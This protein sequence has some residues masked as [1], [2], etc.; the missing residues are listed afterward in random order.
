MPRTAATIAVV[1]L[2]LWSRE[3]AR[4]LAVP[5]SRVAA[6]LV[7]AGACAVAMGALLAFAASSNLP[8]EL[9]VEL[10]SAILG[11]SFG[12]AA[13]TAGAIGVAL[14]AAAPPRTA[15][16]NLLA[17]LPVGPVA[18]RLGQLLPTLALGLGY[19]LALSSTAA[20]VV[21]RTAPHPGETALGLVAHVGLVVTALLVA[22]GIF[23]LTE[24]AA[25]RAA[26]MPHA[27]AT[28]LA[29]AVAL[30]ATFAA[31]LPDVLLPP[32]APG[33]D[34]GLSALLPHRAF[35]AAAAAPS[36]LAWLTP[37]AWVATAIALTVLAARVHRAGAHPRRVVVPRGT[38][39][40]RASPFWA[41]LWLEL[42]VLI[43]TP[44]LVLVAILVP[45]SIAA[46]TL[47]A[48]VPF[49]QP[50][51][52]SLAGAV[53]LIPALLGLHA[54]GRALPYDWVPDHVTARPA[55][56]VLP[57]LTAVALVAS[58]LS[59]PTLGAMLALGHVA[60][61]GV[62]ALA[63]RGLL[64]LTLALACG[65]VVPWSEQQPLSA[66]AG[67]LLLAVVSVLLAFGISAASAGVAAGVESVLVAL[68]A[69]LAMGV[70][71]SAR[72]RST[73]SSRA[74]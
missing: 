23:S 46:V 68:A 64:A 71:A 42:L 65:A 2:R 54:P 12:G 33:A 9:P 49:A 59:L 39:P 26:R 4:L 18:A 31:T 13:L 27:Y 60:P 11:T 7:V 8:D 48:S 74:A 57:Q 29:G 24:T 55:L 62:G 67:G 6:A 36:A 3:V 25:V 45:V 35:A 30:T 38:R 21:V 37:L 15:L 47:L 44:Q 66:S 53:V 16:E 34:P 41:L 14:C 19:T 52:P 20:V 17:L 72:L 28:A 69:V 43:R 61:S 40:L 1:A 70:Y 58:A 22:T 10:R 32:P 73:G 56:R 5:V 50:L 51:V 63:L